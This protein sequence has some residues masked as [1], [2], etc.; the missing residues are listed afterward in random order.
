MIPRLYG[1]LLLLILGVI[2]CSVEANFRKRIPPE[3]AGSGGLVL[4]SN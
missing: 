4:G 3:N 1:G 2:L